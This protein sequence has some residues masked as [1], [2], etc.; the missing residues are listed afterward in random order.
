MSLAVG[1]LHCSDETDYGKGIEVMVNRIAVTAKRIAPLAALLLFFACAKKE[2]PA[3]TATTTAAPPAATTEQPAPT[4]TT[5]APQNAIALPADAPIPASGVLLWLK[6]DEPLTGAHPVHPNQG[7]AVVP[8]AINGHAVLHFDGTD[9]M[10]IADIDIGPKRMPE[11]T[12]VS[13]FRSATADASPLRKLYG[14]DDG[15]YDRAAGLDDRA[16]K[17]NYTVF[18]GNGDD[19]YFQLAANTTYITVDQYTT[20]DF[21]GW[22]NGAATPSITPANWS[23]DALPNL[24]IGGTG[25]VY[26]EF[27]NGD[28]AE[29][30]VYNRKLSDAERAQ[31]VGYLAK[32]YGVTLQPSS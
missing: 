29:I 2:Q 3:E 20:K 19:A 11:G 8:N 10:L 6:A 1:A 13:V 24:Y 7:P 14:D 17:T 31:V 15:G 12:I 32:K 25:T 5:V 23:E 9:H 18:T 30:I 27:W 22:V 26:S 21:T 16:T 28:L 4:T